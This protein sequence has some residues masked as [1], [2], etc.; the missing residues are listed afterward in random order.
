MTDTE[1]PGRWQLLLARDAVISSARTR[2]AHRAAAGE[3]VRVCRGAYLPRADWIPLDGAARHRVLGIAV[4][5]TTRDELVFS[6]ATA[7]AFWR[8]PW[9]GRWPERTDA[10]A[11]PPAS[12]TST[13]AIRRHLEPAADAVRID[14]V[15]VTSLARTVVDIARGADLYRS[16]IVADAALNP[17]G[18][19][20]I[21]QTA[22]TLGGL[23]QEAERVP[24]RHGSARVGHVVDFADGRAGSPGESASRVTM[25]RLRLPVPVLQQTF[26]REGGGQWDTDF[27][28]PDLRFIGEFDGRGKYLDPVLRSG[29][30]AEQVV[31]DEKLREDE[32]RRQS[33]GFAR[34]GWAEAVSPT[35]LGARLRAAGFPLSPP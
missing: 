4:A 29:R 9:Y 25:A 3:L 19:A 22:T 10:V 17:G 20:E 26:P 28:F 7:A 6:H 33:D 24:V 14:G 8:L 35:R 32:L 27:W 2:L 31:L 30:T 23:R 18:R 11:P 1:E 16:V 13:R 12:V 5:A 21:G 34:W 15:L